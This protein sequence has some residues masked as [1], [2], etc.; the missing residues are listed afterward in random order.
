MIS[1]LKAQKTTQLLSV[2]GL[3]G[4]I[5][6]FVLSLFDKGFGLTLWTLAKVVFI[7]VI[8][9]SGVLFSRR[10][11]IEKIKINKFLSLFFIVY[12]IWLIIS[13]YFSPWFDFSRLTAWVFALIPL[14]F[15]L[16][17]ISK[18]SVLQNKLLGSFYLL[19]GLVLFV[20]ADLH[21]VVTKERPSGPFVDTNVFAGILLFFII[22]VSVYLIT[23]KKAKDKKYHIDD[24]LYIYLILGYVA[25]F[26]T[27]SRSGFLAFVIVSFLLLIKII[28]LYKIKTLKR[29]FIILAIILSTLFFVNYSLYSPSNSG[30]A[31]VKPSFTHLAQDRSTQ[32]RLEIWKTSFEIFKQKP[33][34]GQGFG[35]FKA[36]YK[37]ART[38]E[39]NVS[40]GDYAHNDYIQFV[41]EG[42]IIQLLFFSILSFYIIYL[43]A[44]IFFSKR[45]IIESKN[46]EKLFLL[47]LL[48]TVCVFFIQANANFIFYL[49]PNAI[50]IGLVLGYVARSLKLQTV[51]FSF[52][53]KMQLTYLLVVLI[54]V[55][56]LI[57]DTYIQQTYL[58]V[59]ANKSDE[60]SLSK[61][62]NSQ[63]LSKLRPRSMA[64]ARYHFTTAVQ[65]YDK[66]KNLNLIDDTYSRLMKLSPDEA[67]SM[68]YLSIFAEKFPLSYL[69]LKESSA[70]PDYYLSVEDLNL[71]SISLNPSLILSYYQLHEIYL[72]D[73]LREKAYKLFRDGLYPRFDYGELG[74]F[75]EMRITETMMTDALELGHQSDVELFANLILRVNSCNEA[76]NL[77]LLKTVPVECKDKQFILF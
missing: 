3:L 71:K 30:V 14:F 46:K 24:Y 11:D 77:A 59:S 31:S 57:V 65:E 58:Q 63:I 16:A 60:N 69:K 66:S 52:T 47:S 4:L 6:A 40:S 76:A 70:N 61:Y 48:S 74:L 42:G 32:V 55:T 49:L 37:R 25:F 13:P 15:Y 1:I 21:F 12:L 62:K 27:L 8:V 29:C 44:K 67:F 50:L 41:V 7:T 36:A 56:S 5:F 2:L 75:N 19:V 9:G 45:D 33:I 43:Y 73:N 20:W 51:E 22:P 53:K 38:P 17:S 68:Y 72:A 10:N 35:Q 64:L 54:A 18:L 23:A 26:S 34:A 28:H 39:D